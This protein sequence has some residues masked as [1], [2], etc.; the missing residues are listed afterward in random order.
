SGS[1]LP[2]VSLSPDGR[3]T[4][5]QRGERPVIQRLSY[6]APFP[7]PLHHIALSESGTRACST[8]AVCRIA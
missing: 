1:D 4:I 2:G 7:V 6:R 8:F 5:P 3:S